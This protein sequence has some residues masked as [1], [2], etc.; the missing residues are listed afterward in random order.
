MIQ[1]GTK[2]LLWDIIPPVGLYYHAL[3]ER[4][5]GKLKNKENKQNLA[6]FAQ[7]W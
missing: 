2:C 7:Q 6:I 4:A 3:G 1:T 5:R